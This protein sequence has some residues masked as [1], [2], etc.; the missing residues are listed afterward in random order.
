M[1]QSETEPVGTLL[2]TLRDQL[3]VL[4]TLDAQRAEILGREDGYHPLNEVDDALEKERLRLAA[5]AVH[6]LP[7]LLPLLEPMRTWT[8][9]D[10]QKMR[11]EANLQPLVAWS[12]EGEDGA[13]RF[14]HSLCFHDGGLDDDRNHGCF[15]QTYGTDRGE[16]RARAYYVAAALGQGSIKP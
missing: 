16:A 8:S 14:L 2:D 11:K 15:G 6:I 12:E 7:A 4:R 10:L 1:R 9:A 13:G 3:A 5:L